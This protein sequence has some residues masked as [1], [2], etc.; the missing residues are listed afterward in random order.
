MIT[1]AK[2]LKEMINRW[3]ETEAKARE[4]CP[5]LSKEERFQIVSELFNKS[6]GI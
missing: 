2:D 1:A 3:N 4:L 5:E 6:L